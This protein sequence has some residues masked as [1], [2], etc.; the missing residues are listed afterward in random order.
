MIFCRKEFQEAIDTAV[1]PSLQGGP[2]NHQIGALAVALKEAADPAFKE[3]IRQVKANAVALADAL[4]SHGYD[5]VTGGTENHLVLWNARRTGLSGSKLERLLELCDISVNK[6]TVIGDVS[7]VSPGG[8]RL[9]T[10]AMTT[11]GMVERDMVAV[12]ALIDRV[13][14]VGQR[15]QAGIESKKLVDFIAAIDSVAR[16]ELE[17]IRADVEALASTFPMP[18]IEP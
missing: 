5:L 9:G 3:Y 4:Q 2:H 14:R 8:I 15:V 16:E 7:A 12:A 10:P 17:R 18:G 1:F 6:N 11:R 13:V